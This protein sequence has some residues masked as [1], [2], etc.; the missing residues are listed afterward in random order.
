MAIGKEANS[1]TYFALSQQALSIAAHKQKFSKS[2]TNTRKWSF[3][4]SAEQ[5]LFFSFKEAVVFFQDL[6]KLQ[7]RDLVC[8]S[9]DTVTTNLYTVYTVSQPWLQHLLTLSISTTQLE[10]QLHFAQLSWRRNYNPLPCHHST[11]KS[12][13]YSK[14]QQFPC[15]WMTT[16]R[17][18]AFLFLS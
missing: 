1:S 14:D 5:S 12:F 11:D 3:L 16:S 9:P 10:L 6:G 15:Y 8:S 2:L 18:K 4:N 7:L 13:V 17:R